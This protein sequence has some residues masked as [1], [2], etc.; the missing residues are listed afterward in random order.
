MRAGLVRRQLQAIVPDSEST[1]IPA[2]EDPIRS[3]V[4]VAVLV[5][6]PGRVYVPDAGGR[7]LIATSGI[8]KLG[9][10]L[11]RQAMSDC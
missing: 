3:N 1:A 4:S 9:A 2:G 11:S 10:W 7:R 8:E 6:G 5:R